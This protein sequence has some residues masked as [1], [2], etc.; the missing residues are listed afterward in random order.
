MTGLSGAGKT[1]LARGFLELALAQGFVFE[2]VDGD[3]L[4]QECSKDLSYSPEDRKENVRRAARIALSH[5]ISGSHVI[6]S[7]TSPCRE[8]RE[9]V[10]A[11]CLK[12]GVSFVEVYLS[13]SLD[14]C[15]KRDP[16]LLYK[17]QR[18]GVIAHMVGIDL[19]Y[20]EPLH[21]ELVIPTHELTPQESIDLFYKALLPLLRSKTDQQEK[22][23]LLVVGSGRSGTS[24]L[25]KGLEILGANL[26]DDFIPPA[27]LNPTGFWEDRNFVEFNDKILG[28][29]ERSLVNPP[30]WD[31]NPEK[32]NKLSSCFLE[33]VSLVTKCFEQS[34]LVGLK[35]PRFSVL[36]PFWSRVFES[37][38]ISVSYILAV[39]NPLSV[40]RSMVKGFL[41]SKQQGLYLWQIYNLRC[42]IDLEKPPC[43]IVDYDALVDDPGRVIKK[44][45]K[46][47]G[48]SIDPAAM[49]TYV[50]GYLKQS[51]RHTQY[52]RE[53][54]C[55]DPDCDKIMI[56]LYEGLRAM[57]LASEVPNQ[58]SWSNM[59]HMARRSL[60]DK[61]SIIKLA[62]ESI[63]ESNVLK[64]K[65]GELENSQ[66]ALLE[67]AITAEQRVVTAEGRVILMKSSFSW[68]MTAPLRTLWDFGVRIM[69]MATQK[70]RSSMNRPPADEFAK[71]ESV[72]LDG[73][74]ILPMASFCSYFKRRVSSGVELLTLR[75]KPI[76]RILVCSVPLSYLVSVIVFDHYTISTT[77]SPAM[78]SL[79]LL[80][81]SLWMPARW[82]FS[83]AVIYTVYLFT[84]FHMP[85]LYV[86]TNG[87]PFVKPDFS[88]NLIVI[89]F[90][91]L[92]LFCTYFSFFT[93]KLASSK[94]EG[95]QQAHF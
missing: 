70:K 53:R 1:T 32:F 92:G 54:L 38:G 30:V 85:S 18:E 48:L 29:L 67:R 79:G 42:L 28:L 47:L 21:P 93:K 55:Q 20:E 80:F 9:E 17:K 26:G 52:T 12:R 16:K 82:L 31:N 63:R 45:G 5:A 33:A 22:K 10:R 19:P 39:R 74:S 66:D 50:S 56:E 51:L 44:L 37:A 64:I 68:R 81:M 34:S 76:S 73:D 35:D 2:L 43:L 94:G 91:F 14:T 23:L 13:A 4:R 15:Q 88:A 24:L 41:V 69:L 77:I 83:W 61:R 90:F 87:S 58:D 6:C 57:A 49:M 8:T 71:E 7:M 40:S 3:L 60:Q 78:C 89:S 62:D 84:I 46:V 65:V 95:F 27:E 72:G 25:T 11:L 59:K 86:F 75:N 36:L